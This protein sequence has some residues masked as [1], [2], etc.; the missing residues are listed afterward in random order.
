MEFSSAH[1][2]RVSVTFKI[3]DIKAIMGE[4][5]IMIYTFASSCEL[6]GFATMRSIIIFLLLLRTS[7][8]GSNW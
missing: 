5:I 8:V 4:L 1:N 2:P 6:V 3:I 7:D